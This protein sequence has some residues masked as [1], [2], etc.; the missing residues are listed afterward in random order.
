MELSLLWEDCVCEAV[1]LAD[2]IEIVQLEPDGFC[3]AEIECP[4]MSGAARPIFPERRQQH[5][6]LDS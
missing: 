2:L 1:L 3:F 6:R 4:M 5:Q